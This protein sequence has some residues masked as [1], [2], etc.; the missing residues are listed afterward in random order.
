ME[1]IIKIDTTLIPEKK[2]T[3]KADEVK[4]KAEINAI[5]EKYNLK[6]PKKSKVLDKTTNFQIKPK[7]KFNTKVEEPIINVIKQEPTRTIIPTRP[8]SPQQTTR[9]ISPP[10]QPTRPISPPQQ[11]TR[12]IS[13]LQQPTRAISPLQQPT[14]AISTQLIRNIEK[15]VKVIPQKETKE[16]TKEIIKPNVSVQTLLDKDKKIIEMKKNEMPKAIISKNNA[17]DFFNNNNIYKIIP[18]RAS[19]RGTSERGTSERGTSER[20]TSERG[21]QPLALPC[22][23]KIPE[24][25]K[26]SG[27]NIKRITINP[28]ANEAEVNFDSKYENFDNRNNNGNNYKKN[29]PERNIII[30]NKNTHS[31]YNKRVSPIANRLYTPNNNINNSNSNNNN[32]TNNTNYVINNNDTNN[33]KNDSNELNQ[34]ELRRIHLQEQQQ[35][36]IEILKHKKSQIVKLHN[37]KKEIE[38]MKSIEIE[39]QKLRMIQQKQIELNNIMDKQMNEGVTSNSNSNNNSNNN[40]NTN[41]NTN[42]KNHTKTINIGTTAKRIPASL[43]YN[44]DAKKTRK[45]IPLYT[46]NYKIEPK[47]KTNAEI[48]VEEPKGARE[49]SVQRAEPSRGAEALVEE[50]KAETKIEETKVDN[51][52][53][54]SRTT[55]NIIKNKGARGA[56]ALVEEPKVKI[57]TDNIIEDKRTLEY[58]KKKDKKNEIIFPPRAELYN[59]ENFTEQLAISL[60]IQ[61][62][63]NSIKVNKDKLNLD[64]KKKLLKSIYEFTHLDKFNDK[65]LDVIY[66][67][68]K[69]DKINLL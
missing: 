48:N 57:K 44:V 34:L 12:A 7:T 55:I 23:N 63:F 10:Q 18:T 24:P 41:N 47:V 26:Q 8:I 17:N 27:E 61:P 35:K 5:L 39:K 68:L 2:H 40:N 36:E 38:L 29:I 30:Q 49:S 67:I 15:I 37:R 66:K 46:E 64:D 54:E 14:R 65:T 60:G 22:Y 43:I 42:N 69:Y 50:P 20:G 4:K 21:L 32:N 13:P 51:I 59:T 1:K 53:N 58:Y 62:I 9:P 52:I 31:N 33:N 3:K 19:E 11:P 28:N 6:T 25:I 16:S 56:E 45:N